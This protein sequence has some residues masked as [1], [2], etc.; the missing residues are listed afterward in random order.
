MGEEVLLAWAMND[1]PLAP[2]HGAPLRVVVPGYIGARS[3]KWVRGIHLRDTPWDGYFQATTYRLLA[4]E[5]HAAPG[6]GIALGESALN[7][8]LLVPSD[9]AVIAAGRVDVLGYAYAGG[10][11]E[12]VRVDV[13][14]DDGATWQRAELLEDLGPWAWRRW[15]TTLHLAPGDTEIVARAWDSSAATQPKSPAELWN[16]TGYVNN[17]WARVSVRAS[18]SVPA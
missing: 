7:T 4:P 16:P 9:G 1:E 11:R 5:E 18:R 15:R 2:E 3:V 12:V 8:A 17:A 10:A 14:L 13:S 6:A